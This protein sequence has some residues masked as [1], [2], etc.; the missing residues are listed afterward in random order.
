MTAAGASPCKLVIINGWWRLVIAG[1]ARG[2]SPRAAQLGLL[3]Q[4][5]RV[6]Q[7]TL[8]G[9]TNGEVAAVRYRRSPAGPRR[10]HQHQLTRQ[11]FCRRAPSVSRGW[12]A[13]GTDGR[14][15]QPTFIERA[16]SPDRLT[17]LEGL[18]TE[19][20][21]EA[22]EGSGACRRDRCAGGTSRSARKP[23]RLGGVTLCPA[24]P[25]G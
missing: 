25:A 8:T 14:T 19:G 4:V 21:A 24:V 13:T 9:R 5:F 1:R 15:L 18:A 23:P 3:A 7:L 22:A 2:A 6:E 12:P 11:R 17:D 16:T 20:R 10:H